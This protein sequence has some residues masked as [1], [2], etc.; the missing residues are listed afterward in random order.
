MAQIR[1][2]LRQHLLSSPTIAGLVGQRAYPDV[3]VGDALPLLVLTLISDTS[4]DSADGATGLQTAR[5]E[6]L[7]KASS[8]A[9]RDALAEAI[10][11]R[12]SGYRGN[13]GSA[14]TGTLFVQ[15]CE[16]D[17][18]AD[19]VEESPELEPRQRYLAAIDLILSYEA[20]APTGN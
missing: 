20:G 8:P 12:A 16:W 15:N 14:S 5:V 13:M 10:R 2:C 7:A 1:D 4:T 18:R 3:A 19:D 17:N 11:N 6:V 9:G